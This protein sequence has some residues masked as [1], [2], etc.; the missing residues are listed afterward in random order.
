MF[1]IFVRFLCSTYKEY[2]GFWLLVTSTR[3]SILYAVVLQFVHYHWLLVTCIY[4]YV[5]LGCVYKLD[6][7]VDVIVY[8]DTNYSLSLII[9]NFVILNLI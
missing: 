2:S 5:I 3:L 8:S 1:F 6:N 9:L 7:S 4:K